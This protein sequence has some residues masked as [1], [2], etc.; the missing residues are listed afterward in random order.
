MNN[1]ELA[2][3]KKIMVIRHAEKPTVSE[4][5]VNFEGK[6]STE[7]LIVKG[8]LRAGA[9]IPFFN[10]AESILQT[11]EISV[12]DVIYACA[13]ETTVESMR[14]IETVT[15]LSQRLNLLVN[16]DFGKKEVKEMISHVMLQ[17]GTILIC[18]KHEDIPLIANQILANLEA[19][20]SWPAERFD[21]VWIFD[22]DL[23]TG[24]Y[25]FSQLPQNLLPGDQDTYVK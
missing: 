25:A 8:W 7:S 21:I 11:S 19:P 1:N 22:L 3:S 17:S 6:L 12:P 23:S 20:Q 13:A 18:W 24:Q 14:S 10:P 16:K 4:I 9:I 5:G 15:P 2:R